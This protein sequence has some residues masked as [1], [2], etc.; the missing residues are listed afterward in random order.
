MT[1]SP[2]PASNSDSVVPPEADILEEARIAL[3]R[4]SYENKPFSEFETFF[5]RWKDPQNAARLQPIALQE[6]NEGPALRGAVENNREDVVRTMLRLGFEVSESSMAMAL[7]YARNSGSKTILELLF[8]GEWDINR[9]VNQFCPPA[10]RCVEIQ[11]VDN[12]R[13]PTDCTSLLCEHVDLVEYCLSLGAVLNASSLSGHTIMQRAVAYASCKMIK[14]LVQ[15]G[16]VV[17]GTNLL[18]HA[19]RTC[20]QNFPNTATL[21]DRLDVILFLLNQGA[22]IDAHYSATLNP[23]LSSGDGNFYGTTTALHF[24]ISGGDIDLVK[25]LLGKGANVGVKSSSIY[26]SE[27]RE[28]SS[29]ELSQIYGFEQI[30][31]LLED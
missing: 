13:V 3:S 23:A 16:A 24:A 26:M 29:V 10:I 12:F 14:L 4:L 2:R 30:A 19:V 20:T 7:K 31:V 15:N 28:V 1:L 18:P 21:E 9:P 6:F 5:V 22:L 25:L 27:S 8:Q 11:R 17:Q